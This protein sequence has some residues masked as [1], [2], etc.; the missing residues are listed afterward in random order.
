MKN[1]FTGTVHGR[2]IELTEAPGLPD[3]QQVTVVL[4]FDGGENGS[5]AVPDI[6]AM[7]KRLLRSFGAWKEDGEELDKYL[8]WNRQQRKVNRP[9]LPE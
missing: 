2:T 9:E 1:E 7:R 6:E 5:S 3:G 8:E 4:Q